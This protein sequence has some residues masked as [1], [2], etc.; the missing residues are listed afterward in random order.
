MLA[1][2]SW[3]VYLRSSQ[4]D[5]CIVADRRAWLQRHVSAALSRPF[6]CL[7]QLD[8]AYEAADGGL[9]GEDAHDIRPPLDLPVGAFD[10]VRRVQLRPLH[11]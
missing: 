10:W 1:W 8:R 6:L 9:V 3:S 11:R 2:P 7:L 5:H 4:A